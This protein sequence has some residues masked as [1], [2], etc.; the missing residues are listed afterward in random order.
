MIDIF[1]IKDSLPLPPD[2]WRS[3]YIVPIVFCTVCVYRIVKKWR[4]TK[5]NI[6]ASPLSPLE[7]ALQKIAEIHPE[8]SRFIQKLDFIVRRYLELSGIIVK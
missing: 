7:H 5:T 1:D 2:F 6:T 3:L 4:T 8:D